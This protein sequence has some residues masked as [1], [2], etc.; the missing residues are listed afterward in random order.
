MAEGPRG[1]RRVLTGGQMGRRPTYVLRPRHKH[2]PGGHGP[3]VP[4]RAQIWHVG[5]CRPIRTF[6]PQNLN[7]RA[8][9]EKCEKK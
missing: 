1:C 5:W 8:K 2:G 6:G 3:C 9:K 4:E 7:M